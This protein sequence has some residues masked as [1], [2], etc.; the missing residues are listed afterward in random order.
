[1]CLVMNWL[2]C[3]R[4]SIK[5]EI[6]FNC[7]VLIIK[8]VRFVDFFVMIECIF[9]NLLYDLEKKF[10]WKIIEEVKYGYDNLDIIFW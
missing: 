3:I 5:E 9:L 8:E 4:Y 6:V 10:Y 1:M 2:Y 7:D